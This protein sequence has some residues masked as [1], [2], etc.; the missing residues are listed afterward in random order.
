MVR[1]LVLIVL[2]ACELPDPKL[3]Y[4]YSNDP[5]QSCGSSNCADIQIPCPA[6]VSIRVLKPND[7]TTPIVTICE[8]LPINRNKDLCA[9]A[10]IDLSDKPIPLPRETLEV[11]LVIWPRSAVLVEETGE[12]DCARHEVQFDAVYGFPISQDPAPAIGGHTYYHPGDDEIRLTLGCTHLDSLSSCE[13]S[14]DLDVSG[15]VDTFENVGVLVSAFE[16]SSL[17]V[18]VGEPKLEGV[19]TVYEM[20]NQDTS[21]LVMSV[22]GFVPIWQG[23]VPITFNDTACLQVEEDSAQATASVRCTDDN[24]PPPIGD[25]L[26]LQGTYLKKQTLDQILAALALMQFPPNG[27]TVGVVVDAQFNTLA[28]QV[29]TARNATGSPGTVRYL[30]ADRTT[31]TGGPTSSNGIFISLDAQFGTQFSVPGSAEHIGGQIQDKVTV[32]V[33]QK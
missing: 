15:S 3:V 23:R 4:L 27:M 32:V 1:A 22:M 21:S 31:V 26:S 29:V 13:L 10:S 20:R 25:R 5:A 30:S 8:P 14:P 7:P 11:Q 28:G 2:V 33:I 24:V 19:E 9:I 6:V 17:D 18:S 12:L 16:G